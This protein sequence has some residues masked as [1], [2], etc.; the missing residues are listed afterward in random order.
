MRAL[1]LL[2]VLA[3]AMMAK[4]INSQMQRA[5]K[6]SVTLKVRRTSNGLPL[7]H[8]VGQI[9]TIHAGAKRVATKFQRKLIPLQVQHVKVNYY[10]LSEV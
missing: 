1:S 2:W 9:S 8:F 3:L 6:Y 4:S 7:E 5:A 10:T